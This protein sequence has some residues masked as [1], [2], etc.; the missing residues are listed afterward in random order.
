M[1]SILC[2]HHGAAAA[3]SRPKAQRNPRPRF[4][5]FNVTGSGR[6]TVNTGKYRRDETKTIRASRPCGVPPPPPPPHQF[7]YRM[8]RGVIRRVTLVS[9]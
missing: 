7:S 8:P 9:S 2:G 5:S 4:L 6:Y 3:C 1:K